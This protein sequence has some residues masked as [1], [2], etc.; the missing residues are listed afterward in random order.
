MTA[1]IAT[2]VY[3]GASAVGTIVVAGLATILFGAAQR[4]G[5]NAQAERRTA[6]VVVG[7]LAIWLGAV[8]VLGITGRFVPSPSGRFPLIALPIIPPLIVGLVALR[9]VGPLR[10]LLDDPSTQ[11]SVTALQAFRIGGSSLLVLLAVGL[12]PALLAVPLGIGDSLTGL[13]ALPAAAALRAGRRGQVI[14]WNLLGIVDLVSALVLFTIAGP[15]RLHLITVNPSVSVIA[16]T[17]QVIVPT[18][19]VPV[20]LLLHSVSLRAALR[21]RAARSLTHVVQQAQP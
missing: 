6:F 18:F 21:G 1:V 2:I 12:L 8:T 16:S 17:A 3:I 14:A 20:F 10:R 4:A 19:L 9:R 15:G 11:V 7:I 5:P 13:L